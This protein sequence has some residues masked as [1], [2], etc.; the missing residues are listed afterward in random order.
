[1]ENIILSLLLL[2]NMTSYEI[3]AFIHQ[4][5]NTVCSD[6]LGSIQTALK[7]LSE[8]S[9]VTVDEHIENHILKKSYSIT[10]KGI[11]RFHKYIT[12]PMDPNK[13]KNM[14]E[15]KF[16]FLGMAPKK[17]RMESLQS[18]I[19]SLIR[20]HQKTMELRFLMERTKEEWIRK[21]AATIRFAN[22]AE[23]NL[24]S[25]TGDASLETSLHTVMDYRVAYL[26]YTEQ[27][28]REDIS[29]FQMIFNREKKTENP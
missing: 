16:V 3:K 4:S 27:R 23:G 24:L 13:R 7:K 18:Y 6:S 28:L 19:S 17:V 25:F 29:F 5:L 1:M 10:E 14:E 11:Q 9:C 26:L 20:E 2:K 22:E 8:Q 21:A 12:T 15:G